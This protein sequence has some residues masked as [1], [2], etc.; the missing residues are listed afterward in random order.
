MNKYHSKST[1]KYHTHISRK[2]HELLNSGGLS[3]VIDLSG[4]IVHFQRYSIYTNYKVFSCGGKSG[5][6]TF[7]SWLEFDLHTTPHCI[8]GFF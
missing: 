3:A 6:K 8:D 2:M 1:H 4:C 7:L 5:I